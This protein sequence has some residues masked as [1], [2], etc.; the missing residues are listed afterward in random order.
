[1]ITKTGHSGKDRV[2][3]LI[4]EQIKNDEQLLK[5]VADT[6]KN[7]DSC[8][9]YITEKARKHL[10]NQSGYISE[11]VILGWAIHYFIEKD[12]IIKSEFIVKN[13]ENV[14]DIEDDERIEEKP[15]LDKKQNIELIS[16]FDLE[17]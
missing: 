13:S 12:E 10:S 3:D 6:K 5:A 1:M 17:E 15:K 14:T 11:D 9:D 4:L 16:I 2:I 8:W 7:I